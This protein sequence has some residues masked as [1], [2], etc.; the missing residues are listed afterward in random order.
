MRE[1][2][3]RRIEAGLCFTC[4]KRPPRPGYKM[5]E[6]C[7]AKQRAS[8]ALTRA[9]LRENHQCLKC[10]VKMPDDWYYSLCPKC[11]DDNA[12]L[13]RERSARRRAAGQC[14]KCG[15]PMDREGGQCVACLKRQS[16]YFKT[17]VR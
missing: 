12:R 6:I 15:K 16:E 2:E 5:C 10:S 1:F 17:W 14:P 7:A 4:G 11:R 13:Y 9:K 3:L 8:S